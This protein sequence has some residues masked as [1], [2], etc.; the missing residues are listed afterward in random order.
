MPDDVIIIST[1]EVGRPRLDPD[2]DL[3]WT[4]AAVRAHGWRCVAL[5][6][7]KKKLLDVWSKSQLRNARRVQWTFEHGGNVG[8]IA[9][10][11]QPI[12]DI[13]NYAAYCAMT[14]KLGDLP[15][16]WVQSAGGARKFHHYL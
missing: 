16:P 10:P 4:L 15:D 12:I 14:A 2:R 11:T 1:A 9:T 5:Q 3:R 7:R 13:D 6:A 8:L